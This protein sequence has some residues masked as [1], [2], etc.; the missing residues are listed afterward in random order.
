[1]HLLNAFN[2]FSVD[3]PADTLQSCDFHLFF[4]YLLN[5][6]WNMSASAKFNR[7]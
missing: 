6:F 4:S 2:Q 3:S 7:G 1:M 5:T